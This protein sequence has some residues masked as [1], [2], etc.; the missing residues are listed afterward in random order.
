MGEYKTIGRI[1]SV[2]SVP[3]I[4]DLS[5]H[6]ITTRAQCSGSLQIATIPPGADMYIYEENQIIPDYVLRSEKTGTMSNPTIINNIGC[7]SSTRSNK[8]KLS[9]PGYCNVEGMLD[10]TQ[11]TTYTLDIIMEPYTPVTEFGGG[12]LLIP[13]LAVGSL[14]ALLFG[15]KEKKERKDI[16]KYE[17][18]KLRIIEQEK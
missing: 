16:H 1:P 15:K 9:Y 10:I 11:G 12:D 18:H 14:F 2:L 3:Y 13:A 6:R 7:T 4:E 8:F 5:C 17:H